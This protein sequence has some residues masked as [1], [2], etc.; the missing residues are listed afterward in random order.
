M[1]ILSY[2]EVYITEIN[3]YS[4]FDYT[5]DMYLIDTSCVFIQRDTF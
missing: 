1:P 2:F 3:A 5:P 4:F